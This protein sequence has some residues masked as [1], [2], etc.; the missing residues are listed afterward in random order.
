[1]LKRCLNR[2]GSPPTA[3]NP[4]RPTPGELAAIRHYLVPFREA[5][6]LAGA[7]RL[8]FSR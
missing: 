7:P 8:A 1:V 5:L 4:D 3:A 6:A 2:H